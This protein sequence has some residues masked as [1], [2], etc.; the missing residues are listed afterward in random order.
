ME[1]IKEAPSVSAEKKENN[2]N[3]YKGYFSDRREKALEDKKNGNKSSRRM[4]FLEHIIKSRNLT[5]KKV[6][7][8]C[9]LSQQSLSWI[10]VAD[11]TR[12][13]KVKE[14]INKLG[15]SISLEYTKNESVES[16]HETKNEPLFE[17]RGELSANAA[18]DPIVN[19]SLN[20]NKNL[21]FLARFL[22]NNNLSLLDFSKKVGI[23]KLYLERYF[24]KDD[25]R[26]STIYQIA[27][28]CNLK[29]IWNLDKPK[30]N[31][32]DSK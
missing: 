11:D 8:I 16:K 4:Y 21:Y 26:I 3:K 12:L 15:N 1:N 9:G 19:E 25:I 27:E 32:T 23:P 17:I 7:E 5:W 22:A 14:I 2:Y 18:I 28:A 30:P 20:E 13:T 6:A 24:A 31:S 10:M 29:I